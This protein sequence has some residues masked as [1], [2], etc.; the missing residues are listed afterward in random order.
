MTG[1]AVT[2]YVDNLVLEVDGATASV[3]DLVPNE[4][5]GLAQG[6]YIAAMHLLGTAPAS[7]LV[8][9]LAEDGAEALLPCAG[10]VRRVADPDR[11]VDEALGVAVGADLAALG[12]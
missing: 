10:R 12:G 7:Y 1:Q 2:P 3:D 5:A 11:H 4:Q 8:G 9:V 6:F